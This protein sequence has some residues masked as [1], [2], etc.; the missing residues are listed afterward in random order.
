MERALEH[1]AGAP[2]VDH[3]GSREGLLLVPGVER[4]GRLPLEAAQGVL[5]ILHVGVVISGEI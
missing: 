3:A 2:S 5:K 1:P 4:R